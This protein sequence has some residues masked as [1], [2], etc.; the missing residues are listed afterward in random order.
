M[1]AA[2]LCACILFAVGILSPS[3][4]TADI[5]TDWNQKAGACVLEA[6]IYPFAG[7][8][9]M[10][11]VHTAMFDGIILNEA[12]APNPCVLP[13]PVMPSPLAQARHNQALGSSVGRFSLS[14]AA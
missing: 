14:R 7:T 2:Q 10:A 4:S 5:V 9:A 11:I 1:S 3:V 13:Q 12:K 8:R 6:K